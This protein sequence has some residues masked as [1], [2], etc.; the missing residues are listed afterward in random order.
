[1]T[2]LRAAVQWQ[3]TARGSRL[4]RPRWVHPDTSV[5]LIPPAFRIAAILRILATW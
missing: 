1:M 5:T 3:T 2:E 4:L